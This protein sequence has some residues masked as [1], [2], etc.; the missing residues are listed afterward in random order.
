MI[1]EGI[2]EEY[3]RHKHVYKDKRTKVRDKVGSAYN[4]MLRK[5]H[6]S[7]LTCERPFPK[8]P[9][10][11]VT[12]GVYELDCEFCGIFVRIFFWSLM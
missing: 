3:G 8:P 5:Q 12:R 9:F 2:R 1:T 10:L 11:L 4:F 7:F 6:K